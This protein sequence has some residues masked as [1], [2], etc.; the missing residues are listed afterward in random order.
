MVVSRPTKKHVRTGHRICQEQQ[1]TTGMV[2]IRSAALDRGWFPV[3]LVAQR[4]Q[5][6][7]WCGLGGQTHAFRGAPGTSPLTAHRVPRRRDLLQQCMSYCPAFSWR[8]KVGRRRRVRSYIVRS[9][10]N[11]R[12]TTYSCTEN[13][14]SSSTQASFTPA[15]LVVLERPSFK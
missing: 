14:S 6:K 13:A 8:K 5:R 11:F 4:R 3:V 2:S 10:S 15:S 7:Y 12:T 9:K 1:H